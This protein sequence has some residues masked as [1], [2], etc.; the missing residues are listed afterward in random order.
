MKIPALFMKLD[1]QKAFDTVNWSYM[2]EVMQALGFG[3]KWQEWNSI[4]FGTATSRA[5]LNGRQGSS[6]THM[7]GVR[8][9]DLLSPMLFILAID[10]LQKILDLA[11]QHGI[12][13][14]LTLTT[15]KLR[16]SLYADDAAIFLNPN[17]QD[18]QAMKDILKMFGEVAGLVTNLEKSSI[19]PIRCESIDLDH[20]LQPFPGSRGI[21]PCRYLGLQLHTQPLQKIHVQPLIEKIGQRLPGW[22]G[23]LLNWAGRLTLVTSVLSSMLTYHLTIFPLAT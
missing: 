4:L 18:L 14:P 19:H 6:F 10:P 16:T 17:R 8:Q 12:L 22:K 5:L 23:R 1:I 3:L 11:T 15:A 21:F 9:G 7:C 13:T 2:L 20:V